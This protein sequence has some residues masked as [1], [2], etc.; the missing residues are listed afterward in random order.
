MMG[1]KEPAQTYAAVKARKRRANMSEEE[2]ER[3]RSLARRAKY[4]RETGRP[5]MVTPEEADEAR[6]LIASYH[7]AG[8]TYDEMATESGLSRSV[9]TNL[10]HGRKRYGGSGQKVKL[11]RDSYNLIMGMECR[12]SGSPDNWRT[13]ARHSPYGTQRRLRALWAD[14]WPTKVLAP[15]LG[16]TRPNMMLLME[17]RTHIHFPTYTAVRE[18]YE[19]LQHA[20]PLD[21]GCTKGDMARAKTWAAKKGC[22]PSGCWDDDT[23]DDPC[24]APEWT[25]RCGTV[26]G[27][28]LHYE[29]KIPV[30]HNCRTA[31]QIYRKFPNLARMMG[32]VAE[33]GPV[34]RYD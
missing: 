30:C 23:I 6:D 32:A 33:R 14:G 12:I 11:K 10:V 15:M 8:M 24:A 28:K 20:N 29:N 1:D 13:M 21:H 27:Q 22:A 7:E 19:K 34:V 2:R 18:L 3:Q 4:L 5:L 31:E 25:G 16:M 17:D 9:F 26:R